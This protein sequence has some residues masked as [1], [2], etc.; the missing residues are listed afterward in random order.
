MSLAIDLDSV[1]AVLLDDGWHE[2]LDE[3]FAID[4]YEYTWA[5]GGGA[6][7]ICAAGFSFLTREHDLGVSGRILIAGPLTAVRAVKVNV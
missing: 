2:V 7:G 3:S 4:A 6:A 5:H 1:A